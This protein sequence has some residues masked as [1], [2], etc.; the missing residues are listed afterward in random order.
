MT[1]LI[2]DDEQS[3]RKLIRVVLEGSVDADFLEASDAAGALKIA[4]EYQEPIDLL[5]SD[6]VMPGQMNGTEMAAQLFRARP[7]MKVVVMSGYDPDL[8]TIRPEWTF[9]QKPFEASEI[10]EII[11]NV[12]RCGLT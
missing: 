11:G 10:R 5:I 9:I 1:I 12:L 2:V 6:V 7:D 8:L 4:T 3:I